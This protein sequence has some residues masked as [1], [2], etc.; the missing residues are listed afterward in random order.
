MSNSFT[1][2]RNDSSASSVPVITSATAPGTT[3]PRTSAVIAKNTSR[4]AA[5]R[6]AEV[7]TIRTVGTSCLR[8]NCGVVGQRRP[9]SEKRVG[10]ELSGGIDPLAEADDPHLAMYV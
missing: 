6:V 8:S 7:A 1:A 3:A 2:P 10:G 4:F 9:G 5:S